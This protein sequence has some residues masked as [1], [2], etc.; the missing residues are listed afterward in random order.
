MLNILPLFLRTCNDHE[1]Q[2]NGARSINQEKT[3]LLIIP[4]NVKK[5]TQHTMTAE[6]ENESD[7]ME[8][9]FIHKKIKI[10]RR[11]ES[12]NAFL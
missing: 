6:D 4:Y 3:Y 5:Q 12:A 11:Q 10:R 9:T 7:H 1:I 2:S 8:E